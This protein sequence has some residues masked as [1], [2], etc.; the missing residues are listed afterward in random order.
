VMAR[1]VNILLGILLFPS[2]MVVLANFIVDLIHAWL[3]PRI[4]R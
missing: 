3:D 1:D 4:A 2:L